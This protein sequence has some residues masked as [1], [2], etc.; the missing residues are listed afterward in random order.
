M[1]VVLTA[2]WR[3]LVIINFEVN[4]DVLA[5]FVPPG[6][7]LDAWRWKHLISLVGFR[8]VDTRVRGVPV[9]LHTSFE[10]VNLRFYVKHKGT[11]G[12]PRGAVIL[13]EIV[14]L[15]A[16]SITAKSLYGGK[17]S[18]MAMRH[19]YSP[20]GRPEP[21]SVEY[22]WR[23]NKCWNRMGIFTE[24]E[25]SPAVP[26]SEEEFVTSH[27]WGYAAQPDGSRR[28]YQISHPAWRLW[29]AAETWL[30]IDAEKLYGKA[31]ADCL[32]SAPSSAFLADGSPVIVYQGEKL[33]I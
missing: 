20:P 18:S 11:D 32:S 1:K 3:W 28:E 15:P 9:P 23:F 4:P 31:L 16:V 17:Y 2:K 30:D 14:P 29:Q 27:S 33:A 21:R 13:R 7:E 5:P 8:Y 22:S 19:R 25:G 6:M 12:L 24:G 26:G 10:E